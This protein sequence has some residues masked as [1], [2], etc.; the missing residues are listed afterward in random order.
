MN[1]CDSVFGW[2]GTNPKA[3]TKLLQSVRNHHDEDGELLEDTGFK[4]FKLSES[5]FR[6][7]T[8]VEQANPQSYIE[9]MALFTIPVEGQL[10]EHLIYEIAIKEGYELT[11][12]ITQVTSITDQTVYRVTDTVRKQSFIICLDRSLRLASLALLELKHEDL[13]V[14]LD[15]ALD[16][17]AAANLA[18]QCR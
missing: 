8:Q 12:R 6:V 16:D 1:N 7:W 2:P 15:L 14:C 5:H 4:C 17:T 9:Q 13:F 3:A 11:C 10:H 18:L